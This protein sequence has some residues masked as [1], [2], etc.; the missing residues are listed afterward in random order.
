MTLHTNSNLFQDAPVLT[1]VNPPGLTRLSYRQGT[2]ATVLQRLKSYLTTRRDTQLGL[3]LQLDI[4]DSQ[5]WA[6]ALLESWSMVID[7]LSFYQERIVNEGYLGTATELRSIMELVAAIGYQ[8]FPGLSASSYL[9]FT[10]QNTPSV[11]SQHYLIP[12]GVAVQSVPT[13]GQSGTALPDITKAPDPSQLP[14]VFETF[15]DFLAYP[16]WN[17]ILPASSSNAGAQP[18]WPSATSL[19]LAGT[20]TGLIKGDALLI[21]GEAQAGQDR[22]WIFA[23]INSVTPN[24]KKGYTEIT[25]ESAATGNPDTPL[26]NPSPFVLQKSAKLY[27]YARGGVY[28]TPVDEVSADCSPSGIGLPNTEVHALIQHTSGAL[29]AAT[30]NGV[31]RSTNNGETWESASSGLMKMKISTLT[32][33][34]DGKLYAG[35]TNGGIFYSLDA[36]DNWYLVINRLGLPAGLAA[37]LSGSN[38]TNSA[39]A[40]PKTEIHALAAFTQNRQNYL[41]AGIDSGVYLSQD[42]GL[43]WQQPPSNTVAR[44][45]ALAFS[46]PSPGIAPLV[47]MNTGV[48]PVEM[49]NWRNAL[50]RRSPQGGHPLPSLPVN[51]LAFRQMTTIFAGTPQGIYRSQDNALNWTA[52]SGGPTR[53]LGTIPI[54]DTVTIADLNIRRISDGLRTALTEMHV[55]LPQDAALQVD[56]A[57]TR[58]TLAVPSKFAVYRLVL[59]ASAIQVSHVSDIRAFEFSNPQHLFA[60][61]RSSTIFRSQGNGDAWTNFAEQ[62]PL[63]SVRCL[64]AAPGGMFIAGLPGDNGVDTQWS[65]FQIQNKQLD[66]DKTYTDIADGSWLVLRQEGKAA[67]FQ[68]IGTETRT[69]DDYKKSKS[70]TR[71]SLD[72]SQRL[73]AFDRSAAIVYTTSNPLT[74]FHFEPVTG[75]TLA[76]VPFESLLTQGQL[77]ALSGKRVRVRLSSQVESILTLASSDG[78]RSIQLN[79]DSTY[80]LL[81]PPE[82]TGTN[83][84]TYTWKLQDDSGIAGQL[85]APLDDFTYEL[86]ADTDETT[87]ELLTVISASPGQETTL[88]FSQTL[89][90]VYDPM[91]VTLNANIV[92]ATHGQTVTNEVLG[93]TEESTDSRSFALKNNP[94]TYLASPSGNGTPV[95]TLEIAVNDVPWQEVNML[96]GQD[97]NAHVYIVRR[98]S[99]NNTTVIFGDGKE[100]ARLPRGRE[101]VAAN[102]RYGSGSAGNVPANS[103]LT[104]RTRPFGVQSVTNPLSASGGADPEPQDQARTI[105]PHLI[106]TMQRIVSLSDYAA[107]TRLFP[108]ISKVQ[109]L[110][111]WNG[112]V[113]V[114]HLT[115]AGDNGATI[116]E[117]SDI[118]KHLV[119]AIRTSAASP[120]QPLAIQSYE[121][122]YFQLKATLIIT[123]DHVSQQNTVTVNARQAL[124]AAF[125]FDQRDFAQPTSSSEIISILQDVEGV[126]AVELEQ[127]STNHTGKL[128]LFLPALP[129]RLEQGQM[130][131]AQ[132]LLIDPADGGIDLRPEGQG[133]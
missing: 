84:G 10:V 79:K 82:P 64:L 5:S 70:F 105:A 22:P 31:F 54:S 91:T 124:L 100:G 107:F 26:K 58:W 87:S 35:S 99:H 62:V 94:L 8:M 112:R 12:Q 78:K 53:L 60:A 56:T 115:I 80:I 19:R 41:A 43:T 71:V 83:T 102:Y 110:D 33:T 111:L 103:L 21:T 95:S 59:D 109:A 51:A 28:F 44:G 20:K 9:A 24:T 46:A 4:Y 32:T 72:S 104:I 17:A 88:T 61:S 66:L 47:G 11:P 2:Y 97:S 130:H 50:F 34:T 98:D 113:H 117:D 55:D 119:T 23:L 14:Q 30:D 49:G 36:G 40:L 114:V 133:I 123:Q 16:S 131:S 101:H 128:D 121:L 3:P 27:T 6:I 13:Q 122:V 120:A 127:L 15:N 93:G 67:L 38:P 77:V 126:F 96:F 65:R 25:W 108:Q 118:Y 48:F 18:I 74:L 29:F 81:A 37:L 125:S 75:Q 1:R 92:K 106:Q 69:S 45:A 129:A 52:L 57:G 85:A 39:T 7:V 68:V 76:C 132:L 116:A 89:Q 90:N 73:E 86:A 42:G 63:S